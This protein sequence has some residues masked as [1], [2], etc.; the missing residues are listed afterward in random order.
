MTV[1]EQSRR[2]R[3]AARVLVLD[4]ED[5]LLLFHFTPGDRKPYWATVGGELDPG[6]NFVSAARRELFEETGFVAPV[7]GPFAFRE[8]DFTTFDGEPVHAVEQYFVARVDGGPVND[9]GHTDGERSYMVS[10][11]WWTLAEF[12]AEGPRVYPSDITAMWREASMA[13]GISDPTRSAAE[14]GQ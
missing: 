10:H 14:A 2:N 3:L 4:R 11:R 5:R 9:D 13:P 8:T 12:E 6:E 7:H 1:A